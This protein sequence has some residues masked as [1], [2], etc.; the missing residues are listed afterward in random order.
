MQ[1]F[2]VSGSG[3]APKN[4]NAGSRDT[5]AKHFGSMG[6]GTVFEM[7]R[8]LYGGW[9]EKVIYTF[10]GGYNACFP[11]GGVVFDTAGN[12]YGTGLHCG[13]Y[14]DGAVFKLSPKSHGGW[15]ESL[16]HSFNPL[17]PGKDGSYPQG[18]LV[19]DSSGNLYGIT[20]QGG[21]QSCSCGTVFEMSAGTSG[22][23]TERVLHNF[24]NGRDGA[25]PR[26]GVTLDKSGNLYGTTVA[27]GTNEQGVVFKLSLGTS[28]KWGET[29]LHAF[30]NNGDGA[31]PAGGVI[32]DAS[33]NLYGTT[34]EATGGAVYQLAAGSR[35]KREGH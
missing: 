14:F 10:Q 30:Q 8:G 5:Q 28:G 33:G 18:N 9:T 12:L 27:G 29:V 15:T 11:N 19:F 1:H 22:E 21:N 17:G 24:S 32:L 31:Y 7:S 2:R 35:T 23:W 4:A 25:T 20:G 34:S 6:C 26:A 3:S 16:I 13:K